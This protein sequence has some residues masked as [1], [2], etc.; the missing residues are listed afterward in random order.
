MKKTPPYVGKEAKYVPESDYFFPKVKSHLLVSAGI[1][2]KTR[3]IYVGRKR[4][5]QVKRTDLKKKQTKTGQV[6]KEASSPGHDNSTIPNDSKNNNKNDTCKDINIV[7]EKDCLDDEIPSPVEILLRALTN[8]PTSETEKP[9][10]TKTA[11]PPLPPQPTPTTTTT[12]HHHHHKL[13]V[14]NI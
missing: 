11:T 3:I 2:G 14:I 4:P 5:S 9:T 8:K 13:N 10:P 12:H 6:V 7:S 1:L